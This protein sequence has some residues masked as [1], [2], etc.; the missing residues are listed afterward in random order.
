MRLTEKT[1]SGEIRQ[2]TTRAN[3]LCRL[4]ELEDK[5][6]SGQ[7]LEL[8]FN[9]GEKV[10]LVRRNRNLK[11]VVSRTKVTMYLIHNRLLVKCACDS[12]WHE[13]QDMFATKEQAEARLKELKGKL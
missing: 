1:E 2:L 12:E 3:V 4:A 8:P 9:V 10:Y 5:L 11:W 6:E 7:A 13:P